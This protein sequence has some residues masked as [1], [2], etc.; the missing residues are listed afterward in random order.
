MSQRNVDRRLKGPI[1][2][3]PARLLA[4]ARRYVEPQIQTTVEAAFPAV[5]RAKMIVLLGMMFG[6]AYIVGIAAL[7]MGRSVS[8]AAT[9]AQVALYG[10]LAVMLVM[11]NRLREVAIVAVTADEYVLVRAPGRDL[12]RAQPVERIPRATPMPP[13]TTVKEGLAGGPLP[14]RTA[15]RAQSNWYYGG[16][17]QA[18]GTYD[19]G[20]LIQGLIADSARRCELPDQPTATVADALADRAAYRLATLRFHH[21][22]DGQV[23][24]AFPVRTSR[25][26]RWWRATFGSGRRRTVLVTDDHFVLVRHTRDFF[27]PKF[28]GIADRH[29]N[30]LLQGLAD[31]GL[32]PDEGATWVTRVVG[33]L[34]S[35]R[36]QDTVTERPQDEVSYG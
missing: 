32:R 35:R 22:A 3:E 28:E 11:R 6:V 2:G 15:V 24:A 4:S 34:A 21:M 26:D 10:A 12:Q 29:G 7:V 31:N 5:R 14:F 17:A 18:N 13:V 1:L 27:N 9:W 16:Q 20:T 8:D 25:P 23:I 19:M 30:D 36:V 33:D